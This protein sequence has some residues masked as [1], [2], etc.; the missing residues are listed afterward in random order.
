V[1]FE[2]KSETY[3]AILQGR[4]AVQRQ[5]EAGAERIS[6][7]LLATLPG[8]A[9]Q[10]L[11]QEARAVATQDRREAE[12]ARGD[13]NANELRRDRAELERT[14][15]VQAERMARNIQSDPATIIGPD[16]NS[17]EAIQALRNRQEQ[18]LRE[19]EKERLQAQAQRSVRTRPQS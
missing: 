19:I 6:A 9:T 16:G 17:S 15:A 13:G 8:T 3:L 2:E 14:Q 7:E 10:R 18:V 1:S 11:A 5:I 4:I 12:A